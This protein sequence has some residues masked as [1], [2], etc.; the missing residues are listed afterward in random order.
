[1][2]NGVKSRTDVK[3]KEKAR[4]R[5]IR[6]NTVLGWLPRART[7][8]P[9][10]S[11]YVLLCCFLYILASFRQI[12]VTN[13]LNKCLMTMV[14]LPLRLKKVPN[15]AALPSSCYNVKGVVL[16]V[17]HACLPVVIVSPQSR[18]IRRQVV[19]FQ[20]KQVRHSGSRK[21][22]QRTS[23]QNYCCGCGLAFSLKM[24]CSN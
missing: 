20:A 12:E 18:S 23:C 19:I 24:R 15:N 9:G 7:R 3:E 13:F 1:M 22:K 10:L 11:V 21:L 2:L 8:R 6:Y 4:E 14:F 5:V 16:Y 17:C